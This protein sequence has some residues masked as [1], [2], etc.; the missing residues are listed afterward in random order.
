MW[1]SWTSASFALQSFLIG[2]CKY[3][4]VRSLLCLASSLVMFSTSCLFVFG[5]VE[6]LH[7]S[8]SCLSGIYFSSD[9]LSSWNLEDFYPS[10]GNV[11]NVGDC[12]I[13]IWFLYILKKWIIFPVVEGFAGW[14]CVCEWS[15][16]DSNLLC[17]P[18]YAR[19]DRFSLPSLFLLG[20]RSKVTACAW[21]VCRHWTLL[22]NCKCHIFWLFT[23]KK[24][25]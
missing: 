16:L 25:P 1:L 20:Q 21:Y 8:E 18:H 24:F 3:L 6:K 7:A 11:G 23:V 5:H 15:R 22:F 12:R 2:N 4:L 17:S 19:L 13:H 9:F 14:V 10:A